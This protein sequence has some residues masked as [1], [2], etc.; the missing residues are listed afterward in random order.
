MTEYQV[1]FNVAFSIAGFLGGWV[2]NNLS[3]SI[4]RLDTDIREMPKT[5]VSKDD[6]REAMK[7]MKETVNSG[8]EKIDNTL[9][10]IFSR[11]DRKED[12]H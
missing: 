11:L 8:F 12:K 1:L 4:E 6:W 10:T 5:Y 3:K 9:S 2:L 7:D